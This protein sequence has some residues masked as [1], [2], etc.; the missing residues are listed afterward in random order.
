[1]KFDDV[2][3]LKKR[4]EYEDL[5][6]RVEYLKITTRDMKILKNYTSPI[7]HIDNVPLILTIFTS[8]HALIDLEVYSKNGSLI[9]K[10]RNITNSDGIVKFYNTEGVHLK[11]LFYYI[12]EGDDLLNMSGYTKYVNGKPY[13]VYKRCIHSMTMYK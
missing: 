9:R 10:T 11:L 5:K 13:F 2:T 4:V 8:Y 7:T 3:D 12:I 1:M 6:K